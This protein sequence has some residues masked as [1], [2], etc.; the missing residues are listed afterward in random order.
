MGKQ[1]WGVLTTFRRPEQLLRTLA[2]LAGQTKCLDHLVIVDNGGDAGSRLADELAVPTAAHHVTLLSQDHNLGPAGAIAVGMG[3]V[4]ANAG[5]DAWVVTFDDDDPPQFPDALACLWLTAQ[6]LLE[7]S[8]EVGAVGVG[9]CQFDARRVRV[10]RLR[11]DELTGSPMQV[12]TLSGNHHPMIRVA[13]IRDV[14]PYSSELFFGQEE[15]E[16]FLRMHRHGWKAFCDSGLLR[17]Y[18]D[19]RGRTGAPTTPS[20]SLGPADW[21]R[22]YSIRNRVYVGLEYGG[23]WPAWRVIGEVVGKLAVNSIRHPRASFAHSILTARACFDGLTGR[24]GDTWPPELT[25][26]GHLPVNPQKRRRLAEAERA[27]QM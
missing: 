14:G 2:V 3:Y 5:P 10:R 19:A 8:P 15:L 7:D 26:A 12:A 13:A 16:F 11:N 21:R 6:R 20:R 23:R 27:Q 18:R 1:L 25:Q 17:R 9:G 4:A 22:Y 24:L